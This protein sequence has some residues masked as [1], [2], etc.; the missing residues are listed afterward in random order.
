MASGVEKRKRADGATT[1][2]ARVDLPADPATGK[3]RQRSKSFPT[4]KAAHDWRNKMLTEIR[5]GDVVDT[6]TRTIGEILTEW[7][8]TVAA[9]R[10]RPTTLEDYEV[11]IRRHIV[12]RIG[13]MPVQK[14]TAERLQRFYADMIADGVSE[15][16]VHQC[17][18]RLSQGLD[19]AIR[20]NLIRTNPCAAATA[21]RPKPRQMTTWTVPECQRFIDAAVADPLDPFWLLLIATGL[22]RGEALGL[23]WCDIDVDR[24]TLTVRQA[25]AVLKGAPIIQPP[26]T[27]AG[28][29]PVLIPHTL[30]EPLR[31]HQRRQQERRIAAGPA[32]RNLDL[33]FSTRD[34]GLINPN[35][36]TRSYNAIVQ[37]AGLQRIR[38]H[39][40][41]HTHVSLLLKHRVP[42]K[43]VSERVG[44]ASVKTTLDIYQH[45][46]ED[47]QSQAADVMD[48]LLRQQPEISEAS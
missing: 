21:P 48:F 13:A 15:H 22:R 26:K 37:R 6:S 29:R 9:L 23:R 10:V 25:V 1:Y 20:W 28:I 33:V 5:R 8:E 27:D 47:M 38:L 44:H 42:L 31:A 24:R 35:N 43:V 11:T 3:R 16:V 41:R 14:L 17:H 18:K 39:D 40:L 32:W 36:L 7:L 19:Q 2:R 45:V 34:G 30:I 12:P 4:S 46:T